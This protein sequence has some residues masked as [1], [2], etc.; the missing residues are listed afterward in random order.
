MLTINYSFILCCYFLIISLIVE[1][2]PGCMR[3][4]GLDKKRERLGLIPFWYAHSSGWAQQ[5]LNTQ[6]WSFVQKFANP[7]CARVMFPTEVS[8]NSVQKRTTYAM[9]PVLYLTMLEALWKR[10]SFLFKSEVCDRHTRTLIDDQT[11]GLCNSCCCLWGQLMEV[12]SQ[13][14]QL[15]PTVNLG[16]S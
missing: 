15:W 9:Y 12:G 7:L 8:E 6:A 2:S 10:M 13:K 11:I 16:K 5:E 3:L 14:A 1:E 4:S